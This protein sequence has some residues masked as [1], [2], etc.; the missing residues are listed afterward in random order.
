MSLFTRLL[1][2]LVPVALFGLAGCTTY[3]SD[4]PW[5]APE[6]WEGSPTIPGFSSPGY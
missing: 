5:A 6:S 2:L 1:I 3:E 4:M